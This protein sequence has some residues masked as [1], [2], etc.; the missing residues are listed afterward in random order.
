MTKASTLKVVE[1][2]K[3][4]KPK[5][6]PVQWSKLKATKVSVGA[7]EYAIS[8]QALSWREAMAW[9]AS[10]GGRLLTV[11]ELKAAFAL[12]AM[13]LPP[14]PMKAGDDGVWSATEEEVEDG[15]DWHMDGNGVVLEPMLQDPRERRKSHRYYAVALKL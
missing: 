3:T 8:P 9:A 10:I 2:P 1:S 11:T 5:K 4:A 7:M 15:V 6:L 14:R 13:P 12:R